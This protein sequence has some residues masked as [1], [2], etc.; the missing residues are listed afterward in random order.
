MTGY[1]HTLRLTSKE[2]LSRAFDNLLSCE[3][4]EDCLVE[5]SLLR[6][7]FVAPPEHASRLIERIYLEGGLAWCERHRMSPASH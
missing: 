2:Q 7:R 1:V 3:F 5:A 4:V 6:L